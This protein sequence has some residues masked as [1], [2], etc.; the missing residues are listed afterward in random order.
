MNF[1]WLMLIF[2]ALLLWSKPIQPVY[3]A[4]VCVNCLNRTKQ[5]TMNVQWF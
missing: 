4:C 3:V 2:F 1:L 5:M